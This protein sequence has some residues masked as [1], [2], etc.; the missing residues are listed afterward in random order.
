MDALAADVMRLCNAD[1][2]CWAC[3]TTAAGS[4]SLFV[5]M[6]VCENCGNKRCPHATHH[7]HA[8][9][10]SNEPGQPGSRYA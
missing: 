10:R 7:D 5:P 9:T 4:Y 3:C 1:C 8:C 2:P 6:V